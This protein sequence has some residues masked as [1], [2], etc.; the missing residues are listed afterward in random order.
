MG[1]I[2]AD[3]DNSGGETLTLHASYNKLMKDFMD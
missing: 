1:M 3:F 2:E